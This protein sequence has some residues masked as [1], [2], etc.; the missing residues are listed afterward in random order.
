MI[1]A[2]SPWYIS[3]SSAT[4]DEI[5]LELYI[6]TGAWEFPGGGD[7][8][9]TATVT[10]KSTLIDYGTVSDPRIDIDISPYIRDYIEHDCPIFLNTIDADEEGCVWVDY[11]WRTITSG[12]ASAW[13]SYFY[14]A[15][16]LG[17]SEPSDGKNYRTTANDRVM[18]HTGENVTIYHRPN[19]TFWIAFDDFDNAGTPDSYVL[20]SSSG[21]RTSVNVTLDNAVN[22][23]TLITYFAV[24]TTNDYVALERDNGGGDYDV[25]LRFEELDFRDR[26][27]Y[28]L[29]FINKYGAIQ[30]INM[31]G[32]VNESIELTEEKYELS[33]DLVSGNYDQ[34]RRMVVPR[35]RNGK[36]RW[37]LNTWFQREEN[38]EIFRQLFMSE[39]CWLRY[40]AGAGNS[41]I[42]PFPVNILSNQVQL[43]TRKH[44]RLI[45]YT[46]EVEEAFNHRI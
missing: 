41:A 33:N 21:A 9:A 40:D 42:V 23:S 38:N 12:A 24:D 32:R 17:Y 20:R 26:K 15:A 1:H 6:Y 34:H 18:F 46:I 13:T 2:R 45:Q 3:I 29:R 37:T 27:W 39:R 44:D 5:E 22:T 43:K 30:G 16:V 31:W 35:D 14:E 25:L 4:A 36:K 7:R 11:R 10:L 28:E 8:P 19:E